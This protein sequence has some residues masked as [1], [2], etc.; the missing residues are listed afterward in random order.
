MNSDFEAVVTLSKKKLAN[1]PSTA[2]FQVKIKG[3]IL[4]GFVVRRGAGFFAYQNLCS[5]LPVTLD[6][7]DNSFFNHEKSHLQCQMHGAV[8]EMETG[9][10]VAGP[11]EGARLKP[12]RI[13]EEKNQLII[14]F[15]ESLIRE[16]VSGESK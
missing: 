4:K 8:Y 10:C 9:L 1:D 14:Y 2:V 11:C 13:I 15:P 3:H 12:L 6:L 5:H 16:E 7:N